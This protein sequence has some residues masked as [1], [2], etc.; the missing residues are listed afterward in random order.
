MRVIV[1]KAVIDAA[2]NVQGVPK[3]HRLFSFAVDGQHVLIANPINGFADWLARL[4]QDTHDAY[5]IAL[6][7][8][9]RTA[10]A[11]DAEVSTVN[12]RLE[13]DN[14]W[15][16]PTASLSLDEAISL[17]NQPLGILVENAENDWHFLRRMMS[18]SERRR[19]ELSVSKR[20]VEA[21]HGGG[22]DIVK[23]LEDRSKYPA[24]RL[25]TFVI[26]D[27][28][29]RHPDELHPDWA[30]TG[31]E[32]CQGFQSEIAARNTV[33]DR[34]WRLHR[35]S[36]ESYLPKP[37]IESKAASTQSVRPG[38]VEAFFRMPKEARWFFNMKKGFHGD[39]NHENAHRAKNLYQNLSTEDKE[40]L[41]N[42]F[43]GNLANQYESSTSVDFLWDED[44][45][46]E[47]ATAMPR[48]MRLL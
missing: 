18:E 4:D 15:D 46:Q 3:L 20:W 9:A 19:F 1:D 5:Q 27:S 6:D 30:P 32:A 21:L 22:A 45:L 40:A 31:T 35:R 17:L 42:G 34:F 29:R 44:A 48:I 14:D 37:E 10:V 39:R 13:A 2:A 33:A 24:R 23:R 25:R 36:I 16:S 43:G 47:A 12:V 38:A 7:L 28:D 8:S 11:L 26:F 41:T